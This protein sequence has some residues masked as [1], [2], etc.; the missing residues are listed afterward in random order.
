MNFLKNKKVIGVI[1]LLV[2]V[3]GSYYY[4]S[5]K[6]ASN[7]Q[8]KYITSEAVKGTLTTSISATGNII[9]D[10]SSN[11]D[12]TISG[13]VANLAVAVGDSVKK[14]QFLFNIENDD[15]SVS[16]AKAETSYKQALSSLESAKATKK[17]ARADLDAANS[18]NKAALKQ[19]YEAAVAGVAAAEQN[20]ASA[21]ADLANSRKKTAERRVVSP[22]DGTVNAVNIKNGDDLSKL[23]SGSARQVPIIIGDLSTM[24]AQ[25]QVNEVDIASVSIGQKAALILDAIENVEFSGKIEKMDSL[26]TSD[27]GVVTYNVIIAFDSLD[28]R[29]KPEMSVSASICTG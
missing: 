25:V 8:V 7:S 29:I 26:G 9:V 18:K 22:I 17:S 4:F 23:S 1:I 27:Q 12:P 10:Q 3:G 13:T 24:K 2:I 16:V 21:E 15:L 11:I 20:L 5:R 19:K 14:G 6:K 28:S